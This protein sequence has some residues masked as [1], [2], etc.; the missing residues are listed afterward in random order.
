MSNST[1]FE[2]FYCKIEQIFTI[3]I[4]NYYGSKSLYIIS[5]KSFFHF[6][7]ILYLNLKGLFEHKRIKKTSTYFCLKENGA[8]LSLL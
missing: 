6:K 2:Q 3:R 4:F 7:Y 1:D 8:D 5:F